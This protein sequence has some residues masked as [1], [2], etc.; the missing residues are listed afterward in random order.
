MRRLDDEESEVNVKGKLGDLT[1]ELAE[2]DKV[3]LMKRI[4]IRT[5]RETGGMK[6]GSACTYKSIHALMNTKFKSESHNERSDH[7]ALLLAGNWGLIS[8]LI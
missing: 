5:R 4:S 8:L 7:V 6:G 3:L 2:Q 1:E